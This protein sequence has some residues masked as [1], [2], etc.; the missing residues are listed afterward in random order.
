MRLAVLAGLFFSISLLIIQGCN[1]DNSSNRSADKAKGS[2]SGEELSKIYCSSCHVYPSPG[3]LDKSTWEKGVLPEMA[4]RLGIREGDR[5]PYKSIEPEEASLIKKAGIYPDKPVLS[6]DDWEKI[7]RF[8]L[9]TAPGNYPLQKESE[10]ILPLTGFTPQAV[11]IGSIKVPHTTLVKTDSLTGILYIGDAEKGLFAFNRRLKM[12]ASWPVPSAPV[13][14][15]FFVP[16]APALLCIGSMAPTEK[17]TGIYYPLDSSAATTRAVTVSGLA[18]PVFCNHADI[19]NDGEPDLVICE[20]GNHTGQL[21]W[22]DAVTNKKYTIKS[23]QGAIRTV[24][25][26]VNGDGLT[27]IIALFAQA[28]EEI[29]LFENKGNNT[30]GEKVLMRFPPV[31]GS[32]Y[33][34]MADFNN[35]GFQD[36]LVTAGDNWDLSPIRKN[37]HGIR[38]FE[39]D[40]K[41]NFTEKKFIPLYGTSK[42]IACDF[43]NDGD[44][45]IAATSFYDDSD[46]PEEGFVYFENTGGYN[47]T[48]R[49][50]Q[51]TSY[52]KWLTMDVADV[53]A[54]GDK[55]I[56][57]GSYFHNMDE[58]LKLVTKKVDFFP[59]AEILYNDRIK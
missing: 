44:L 27:D 59:Q 24:T 12:M 58:F 39:N 16:G 21:C 30:F 34:E 57:L 56:I 48:K 33:F 13:D 11:Q 51:Q 2:G 52:G 45:D 5:D 35:D 31:Y 23:Q 1:N 15:D 43:D 17:K 9:E 4:F 32:N 46:R 20:F 38:I 28:Q 37:Y 47:Y 36:I 19:N 50:S 55:D 10:K 53:D 26:D 18:R 22:V 6:S 3:L 40:G 41:F 42:A 7:R 49:I 14:V 54:D 25:T 29:I 8:Y